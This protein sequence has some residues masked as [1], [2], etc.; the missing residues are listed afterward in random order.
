MFVTGAAGAVFAVAYASRPGRAVGLE[1]AA[2]APG[3]IDHLV[4]K[5]RAR[6]D[7]GREPVKDGCIGFDARAGF[8]DV[9]FGVDLEI[10]DIADLVFGICVGEAQS[11][12]ADV[13]AVVTELGQQ[14][15]AAFGAQDQAGLAGEGA[16]GFGADREIRIFIQHPAGD[17]QRAGGVDR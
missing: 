11:V 7:R 1:F 6:D 4:T 14:G 3:K 13:F 5:L 15:R 12:L 9:G 8:D 10:G 2:P 17:I 16:R